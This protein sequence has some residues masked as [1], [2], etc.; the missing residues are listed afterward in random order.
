MTELKVTLEQFEDTRV[1]NCY[2]SVS[3]KIA[4]QYIEGS[5]RRIKCIIADKINIQSS[6]MPWPEGYFILINQNIIKSLNLRIGDSFSLKIEKD[7]S[8]YGMEMPEELQVL[9]DQDEEGNRL[10]HELTSGKMRNLIYIVSKVKNTNS[11]LN[12]SL[13]IIDH[14]RE[15]NGKL[16]FKALNVKLKEYNQRGK[17]NF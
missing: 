16:D 9:L 4:S 2:V 8:E 10:F 14:L 12:K 15:A 1:Y 13:A 6:L 3:E 5:N 7:T 11:R 17:M